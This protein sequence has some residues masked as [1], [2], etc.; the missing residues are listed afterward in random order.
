MTADTEKKEEEKTPEDLFKDVTYYVVGDIDQQVLALL[1]AGGAKRDSYLSQMVSHVIA[2]DHTQDDYSEAK[3]LFE[4]PV[5]T[6]QWVILSVK[7]KKRLPIEIF[8]PEGRLLS[9]VVACSSQLDPDD[10]KALWGMVTYYGGRCQQ[11]LDQ[12]CTHLI[13]Y[14]TESEKYRAASLHVDHVK[15]VTPDW[16][17]DSISKGEKLDEMIYDPE[18]IEYPRPKSPTPPPPPPREPSPPPVMF[19]EAMDVTDQMMMQNQYLHM[20]GNHGNHARQRGEMSAR[21]PGNQVNTPFQQSAMA[22]L[23]RRVS[24][25]E[26]AAGSRPPTPSAKE[27]LA[28][29]VNNRIQAGG[30][31]RTS[32]S[33]KSPGK[34]HPA[35]PG[36]INMPS[37]HQMQQA[38][39]GGYAGMPGPGMSPFPGHEPMGMQK[40]LGNQPQRTL[41][42]ITNSGP[43]HPSPGPR[44]NTTKINQILGLN[45]N[46]PHRHPP[47]RYGSATGSQKG[48]HPSQS[49]LMPT[50]WGHDP[51]DNV[52]ADMCLLGCVFYITDYQ[53]IVGP[54]QID[55]WKKVISQHGG[56]VDPAYSNRVSHILCANQHSDVF[57]LGLKDQRRVVTAYW[58][59]DVLLRKRML[60]PWQALH[61]PLIFADVKPCCNQIIC[62]TNFEGDERMRIKQ[63]INAIGAKYTGYMTHSNSV[64]VC[65]RPE[66]E[67]YEKAKEW[68]LPVVNAQWLSDLV[69]G[70]LDAL[71]LPINPR[72]LQ[73]VQGDLFQL[74]TSRIGHMLVGWRNPMKI[75]KE[76]WKRF[77]PG[78]PKSRP[79]SASGQENVHIP[80]LETAEPPAKKARMDLN[81]DDQSIL[82]KPGPRVMFTGFPRGIARRLQ[83]NAIQLGANI[84]ENPRYCTHL[85][86]PTFSRTLKFFIAVNVCKFVVTRNW[87][88]DSIDQN[89]FLD[90]ANYALRDVKA[91]KEMQCSLQD[92]LARA[93]VRP[94]FQGLTF[95]ITPSVN[96]PVGDLVNIVESAG[97]K[98]VKR[99]PGLRTFLSMKDEQGN[100]KCIL[101][102]CEND[103]HLCRDLLAKNIA[104]YNAEFI[105]T[106]VIRQRVDFRMFQIEVH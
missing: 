18:L 43:Q 58:L 70:N 39:L 14:N 50:Y 104:L 65:K 19:P 53:K 21:S 11:S 72:Y 2:D 77:L 61:I 44:P 86:T 5:V 81:K 73:T 40:Q 16:V 95:Y 28:R 55:N 42:N 8:A 52:P 23:E 100:P 89:R 22:A 79:A 78:V 67:K 106:G 68:H 98:V 12:S 49:P 105:L 34:P 76:V 33:P 83:T 60:P 74:D 84:T 7:C 101:I 56:Q 6:S 29:M 17:T 91:E 69:L 32:H 97:G 80:K 96:P 31:P 71:K 25:E 9:G 3:E 13:A 92:S 20:M 24:G 75:Q 62:V 10:A 54:D 36:G 82:D 26:S 59:N 35:M 93:H 41:R 46:V 63:M 94:L 103:I 64:L 85:V 48:Q 99:R 47:P 102:T 87:I 66:G 57:A 37:P 27:A 1:N 45:M 38:G 4:L 90:E 51:T 30:Q 88:E 15:I